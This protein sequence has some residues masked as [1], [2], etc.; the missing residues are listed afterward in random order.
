MARGGKRNG[1]GRPATLPLRQ[2]L[3]IGKACERDWQQRQYFSDSRPYR[4]R[5]RVIDG[6]V[7]KIEWHFGI[8]VSA[9][10]VESCW[11]RY[12]KFARSGEELPPRFD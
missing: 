10:F 1:A 8:S 2:R 3:L 7:K 5:E 6:H 4:V 11:T 9:R 12:R